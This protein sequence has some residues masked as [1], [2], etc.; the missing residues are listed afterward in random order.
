M[1]KFPKLDFK[2]SNKSWYFH[3]N[4]QIKTQTSNRNFEHRVKNSNLQG[5][6]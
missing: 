6:A 3:L 2:V 1:L 5:H 4:L